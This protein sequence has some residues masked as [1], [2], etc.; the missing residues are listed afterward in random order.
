MMMREVLGEL[1]N[2]QYR[3][4]VGDI[5]ASGAHLLQ[6]INDILDLSKAEAGKL[7]LDE[8]VFDVRDAVRAVFQLTSVRM[9]ESGLRE[10]LDVPPDL[11]L[12][13]GPR[14]AVGHLQGRVRPSSVRR[15]AA[16]WRATGVRRIPPPARCARTRRRARRQLWPQPAA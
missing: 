7:T 13:R 10:T 14:R 3:S 12:L 11:P 1:G 16:A 8:E 9:S 5:H 4:Y 6:I 2:Q 15:P